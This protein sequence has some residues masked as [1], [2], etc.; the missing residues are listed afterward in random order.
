MFEYDVCIVGTGRVGLPLG[1]SLVELGRS[2]VGLDTNAELRAIV[3]GGAMPFLEPGFDEIV[4]T[5]KLQVVDDAA[6]VGRSRAIIITVG[7]PLHT[8]IETDLSQVDRVLATLCPHLRAGQTICLRSTVAPGTTTYVQRWLERHTGLRVGQDLSLAFCPERLAEGR[9]REELTKLPQ[10]IGA[11]D[12][13]S[14]EAARGLFSV[15]GV[16]LL[17]TDFVSAELAKLFNNIARYVNFALANQLALVADTF[18]AHIYEIRRL[19]NTDY[20]RDHVASP[21]F[22]A[23]TCLRKDFG[24]I[25]EW[26]A[27]PDMLLGAWKM[28]EYMP[29]FL[30]HHLRQRTPIHE[31]NVALLGYAFKADTDDIRDSLSPKLLRYLRRELP[32]SIHVSDPCLPPTIDDPDN[33]PVANVRPEQALA[34]ADC[35]FVATN[36]RGYRDLLVGLAET[37]PD[38]WVADI[39]NTGRVNRIFYRA[40]ELKGRS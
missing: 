34:D 16:D 17:D 9:A 39:W 37:R 12:D 3:N 2:V 33:G 29:A 40:G 24:M 5:R 4:A 31:R 1:L 28:N 27:Y 8:H 11:Q 36:H 15:F 14:R 19:T 38:A 23:G 35:V 13:M 6:V 21:G 7:T 22:T 18:G 30:V 32:A 20:P 26:S 10:I 25:N